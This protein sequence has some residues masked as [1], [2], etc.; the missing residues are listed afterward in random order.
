MRAGHRRDS[1]A[2]GLPD[3]FPPGDRGYS[4]YEG[5]PY[6]EYWEDPKLVRLDALERHLISDMLPAS[7][8]RIIDLGCGYG[9]LASCYLDRFDQVFLCDGSLSLLR[10]AHASLGNRAFLVAADIAH[11]PFR[12]GSFDCSLAIRVLHHVE[13]LQR[14]LVEI[15]RVVAGDGRFIFSYHNKRN[16]RRMLRYFAAPGAANPF[17]PEPFELTPTL[18]S[19]HPSEF[20]SLMRRA[21]FS[22]PDYQGAAVL[23]LPAVITDGFGRRTPMG[24]RLAPFMGRFRLAPWLI[25]T[26]RA[27]RAHVLREGNVADDILQ[28]PACDG[29]LGRSSTG[30][31]CFACHRQYPVN[32]GIADF[33]L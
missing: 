24:V 4:L 23:P 10:D 13:D 8:R 27:E 18:I 15:H 6:Q 11:L 28:C 31:E 30:F 14:A 32:G 1:K 5:I 25:G 12:A 22:A 3:A 7:G 33:R 17:S 16:A 19:H 20:E 9:R 21:G 2:K 26:S 29:G